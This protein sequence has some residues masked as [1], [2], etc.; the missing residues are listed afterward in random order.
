[1]ATNNTGSNVPTTRP[2]WT[3]GRF[4]VLVGEEHQG[5]FRQFRSAHAWKIYLLTTV[6]VNTTV[7]IMD[8]GRIVNMSTRRENGVFPLTTGSGK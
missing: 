6:P 2:N 4:A 3:K 5:Y 7:Y 1:M 8:N